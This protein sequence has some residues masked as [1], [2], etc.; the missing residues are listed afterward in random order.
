[1]ATTP[2]QSLSLQ[3]RGG[4]RDR[5]TLAAEPT[6]NLFWPKILA[7]GAVI[8]SLH[9]DIDTSRSKKAITQKKLSHQTRPEGNRRSVFFGV[10]RCAPSQISNLSPSKC[11]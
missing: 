2:N 3:A 4:A 7:L 1:M 11:A 5:L 9:S 10:A 8:R 6:E